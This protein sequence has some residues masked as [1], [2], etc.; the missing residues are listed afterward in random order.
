MFME[1]KRLILRDYS[2]TDLNDYFELKSCDEVWKFSTNHPTTDFEHVKELLNELIVSQSKTGVGFCALIEKSSNQYIGEAGILSINNVT[3]RCAI[4]YN[5]LPAFWNNGYA[6]E[7]SKGLV[8]YAFE[9][10]NLERVEALV[11]QPN[12]ASCKVLEKAG[13]LKEGLLKHFTKINGT[14]YDV[15]YYG[16]TRPI[17]IPLHQSNA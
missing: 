16:I 17:D 11:M 10:L 2:I 9:C 13:L 12:F 6:T 15:C 1:T 3:D 4:G 14:Y 5:L 7:I 8:R